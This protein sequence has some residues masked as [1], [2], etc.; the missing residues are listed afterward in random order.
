M[1]G[2]RWV[3]IY[4]FFELS[5]LTSVGVFALT[6]Q[7]EMS[8]DEVEGLNQTGF[9]LIPSVEV[10]VPGV[11]VDFLQ[12]SSLTEMPQENVRGVPAKIQWELHVK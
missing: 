8:N 4:I 2:W 11:V 5:P 3:Y 10:V 9:I 6:M 12:R 1:V 7:G